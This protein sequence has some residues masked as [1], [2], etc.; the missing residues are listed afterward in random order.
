MGIDDI[1]IFEAE[2]LERGLGTLNDVLAGNTVVV[3]GVI[4]SPGTE[5]DLCHSQP[6]MRQTHAAGNSRRTFVLTTTSFLFQP[7]FLMALPIMISD[8]PSA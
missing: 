3:N 8:W 4:T 5:V 6:C 7:N 1:D 2:T